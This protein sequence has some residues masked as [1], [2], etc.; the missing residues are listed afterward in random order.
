MIELL[1]GGTAGQE[2][3]TLAGRFEKEPEKGSVTPRM[4]E[5]EESTTMDGTRMG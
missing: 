1:A 3:E 5:P 4:Q 2:T